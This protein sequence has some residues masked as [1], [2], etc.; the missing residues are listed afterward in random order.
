M[1]VRAVV[2]PILAAL[3]VAGVLAVQVSAGG[4]DFEPRRSADPCLPRPV[5]P[6]A[7]GFEGL[8]EELVL[9]GLDGAACRLGQTRESLVLD[10]ADERERSDAEI[11]AVR[12]GLLDAVDRLDREGKLPKISEL[13]DEALDE[14]DLNRFVERAIRAI[15]DRVID[16]RLK[17]DNV[18]RRGVEELDIRKLLDNLDEPSELNQVVRKAI[19]SAVKD[20]IIDSLKPF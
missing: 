15:P 4:G 2:L 10:L 16:N 17:T 12:G 3:L 1:S 19:T 20:E 5:T 18:L 7:E 11:E 6:V 8:A 14:A 13:T 9:I